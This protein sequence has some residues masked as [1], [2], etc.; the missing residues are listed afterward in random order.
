MQ[1]EDWEIA[2]GAPDVKEA[3]GSTLVLEWTLN[4]TPDP[5]WAQ[6]L[7]YSGA[8]KSGSMTFIAHDPKIVGNKVSMV[9]EDRDVEAA[10]RY[11]QQSIPLANQ[12]FESQVLAKRRR[13]AAQ[14]QEQEAATAAR[15]EQ[16]RDRLRK[17]DSSE[18]G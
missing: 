12:K 18:E 14:R 3:Q 1:E 6:F 9:V 15:M 2:A 13:E 11:V 16:A 8:P 17:L 4:K 5:E 10:A 7:V